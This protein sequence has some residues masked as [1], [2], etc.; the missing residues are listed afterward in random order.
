MSHVTSQLTLRFK[1]VSC[2]FPQ[3]YLD[4]TLAFNPEVIFPLVIISPDLISGFQRDARQATWGPS[5]TDFHP[6]PV[7][8]RSQPASP[9]SDRNRY[10]GA[11]GFSTLPP[12]YPNRLMYAGP[13]A[14]PPTR[15]S[16]SYHY[17]A[18]LPASPYGSP[19]L[20]SL[21]STV[22]HPPPSAPSISCFTQII[23]PRAP[24]APP[25]P[26]APPAFNMS[27]TPPAYNLLSAPLTNTDFLSQSDEAPP[28]YSLLFP[29]SETDSDRNK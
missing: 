1:S 26:S 3:V 27:P 7:R 9:R 28:A 12:A 17:P 14:A 8:V 22:L 19:S 15:M 10:G 25:A 6:S 5:N 2:L 23:E 29:S 4:V 11:F 16:G 24:P 18:S 20:S 21:P 13:H